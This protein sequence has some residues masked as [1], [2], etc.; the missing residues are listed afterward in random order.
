M[1]NRYGKKYAIWNAVWAPIS[2]SASPTSGRK[3]CLLPG[4][5][6]PSKQ[7]VSYTRPY[8]WLRPSVCQENNGRSGQCWETCMR[9]QVN[10]IKRV[11]HLKRPRESFWNWRMASK[12]RPC[13]HDSWLDLRLHR[14]S[15]ML[16]TIPPRCQLI[17]ERRVAF[18]SST[19]QTGYLTKVTHK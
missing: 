16:E 3:P 15:S 6:E 17:L 14:Y 8:S 9:Q 5:R 18:D 12:M 11:P 10:R 1:S 4:K 7:L 19:F 2:V 13:V